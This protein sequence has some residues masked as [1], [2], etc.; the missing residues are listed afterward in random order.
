M[1]GDVLAE[2]ERL[3]LADNTIVVI[4]GGHGWHLGEH[5]FWGEH[6]TTHLA[7]RLPL[8]VKVPGKP[9]GAT[10][11]LVEVIDLYPTLCDLAGLEVP[12]S[13]QGISFTPLFIL[14]CRNGYYEFPSFWGV[15]PLW[16][17]THLC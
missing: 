16:K 7:M 6:N 2:L 11:S 8:I 17:L 3:G 1:T 15:Y 9:A 13:V 12:S 5:N 10:S 4:W 14:K